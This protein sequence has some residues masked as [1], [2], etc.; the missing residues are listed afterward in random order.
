MAKEIEDMNGKAEIFPDK[1]PKKIKTTAKSVDLGG[2]K[3]GERDPETDKFAAKHTIAKKDDIAG[4]GDE[5]YGASKIKKAL[6]NALNSRL[7]GHGKNQEKVYEDAEEQIN[8]ISYQKGIKYTEK[9]ASDI[10]KHRELPKNPESDKVLDKRWRGLY[11]VAGK[12]TGSAKVPM[13]NIP[14]A[15]ECAPDDNGNSGDTKFSDVPT[16]KGKKLILGGKLKECTD[17]E[18]FALNYLR[19]SKGEITEISKHKLSNYIDAADT[20]YKHSKEIGELMRKT[21]DLTNYPTNIRHTVKR[22]AGKAKATKKL[23]A[24]EETEQLDEISDKTK[25]S[26]LRKAN[27]DYELTSINNML[28]PETIP[29]TKKKQSNRINGMSRAV[30]LNRVLRGDKSQ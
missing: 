28:E 17:A 14:E 21:N 20:D 19:E 26:Y 4:N 2:Y 7:A 6:D 8:E 23:Y 27:A 16:P 24:A 11:R 30:G 3:L 5:V 25:A 9:A 29:E 1:A 13:T 10:R 15:S 12:I 22:L 18:N